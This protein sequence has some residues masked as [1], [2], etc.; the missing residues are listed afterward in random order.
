MSDTAA[1]NARAQVKT[2]GDLIDDL[3]ATL[4]MGGVA[5]ARR[6]AVDIIAALLEVPR[7]WPL[8]HSRSA[9]SA[10][11]AARSAVSAQRL[12]KGMPFSYAVESAPFRHLNLFVDPRVLIPRPETEHL[13]SELLDM[14]E[15]LFAADE[16]WGL[17]IDVGTGSGAIALALA[18][19]GRFSRVIG[20]DISLD[21]LA[22]AQINAERNTNAIRANFELHRG[23]FLNPVKDMKASVVVSNP[24]YIA[25]SEI[26]ALP[27]SV[28]NW[29]PPLALFSGR[30]GMAAI[31][32]IVREGAKILRRGGILAL[33]V[34]E[35]RASL[36][37]EIVMGSNAYSDVSVR[38]DL[39]GRER[40]VFATR[41]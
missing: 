9:I 6:I 16:Y 22:V 19:E 10:D 3:T 28:R 29:E 30:D 8:A 7:S 13:V 21:A 40:F 32:E 31:S 36:A 27:D 23:S 12:V 5:S 20:T 33:E 34:D 38:L 4:V 25:Y 24:P 39:A 14:C 37:A 18:S 2:V 41:M 15:T 11:I 26:D 35:R 17:A 1:A